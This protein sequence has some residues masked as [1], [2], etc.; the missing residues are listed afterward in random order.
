[1]PQEKAQLDAEYHEAEEELREALGAIDQDA[2]SKAKARVS[3]ERRLVEQHL[4]AERMELLREKQLT[5]Q[6][7][8][9]MHRLMEVL[10]K[11]KQ[12]LETHQDN[13]E[14]A[15][16]RAAEEARNKKLAVRRACC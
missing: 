2:L 15:E 14:R 10:V 16:A 3:E 1:M 11:K 6:F 4:E 8:E 5:D 7:D 13:V 12:T 9:D